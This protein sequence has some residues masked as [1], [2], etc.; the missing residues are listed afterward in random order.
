MFQKWCNRCNTIIK[1]SKIKAL[2]VT[3]S[4]THGTK[5][6]VTSTKRGVTMSD[7]NSK[8]PTHEEVRQIM[9]EAYNVFYKKW[10]NPSTQYDPN[11]MWQEVR[12]MDQKYDCELCHELLMGL[13]ESIDREIVRRMS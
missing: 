2:A 13:V 8:I 10:V 7:I 9:N 4:V 6:G 11:V 3:P 5:N 12:A 1:P